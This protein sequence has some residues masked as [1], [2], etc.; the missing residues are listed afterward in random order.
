VWP[1]GPLVLIALVP[2]FAWQQHGG[3]YALWDA[4][5]AAGLL[6]IGLLI[7]MFVLRRLMGSWQQAGVAATIIPALLLV[8]KS[9]K[10]AIGALLAIV[11]LTVFVEW[12]QSGRVA[13]FK[14]A[15]LVI[16]VFSIAMLAR[17]G[18]IVN[19]MTEKHKVVLTQ[20]S[21]IGPVA[22][23]Q[24]PSIVHIVMDAYGSPATLK[25][26]FGHD[27][28]PFEAA[29]RKRGFVV[30]DHVVSPFN[31]TLFVIS[32]IMSGAEVR[33]AGEGVGAS[34]YRRDL[35]YTARNGAVPQALRAAGYT[36]ATA[37]S[38]YGFLDFDGIDVAPHLFTPTNL[39]AGL[40]SPASELPAAWVRNTMLKSA[41]APGTLAEVPQPYFYFQHLLAPHPPFTINS[42]GSRRQAMSTEIIDGSHFVMGSDERRAEYIAGYRSKAAFV[43]AAILKQFDALPPGPKVVIIHGDHGPGALLDTE[44]AAA[45]C[46]SERMTTFAAVYSNVP[47]VR[48][49]FASQTVQ[50]FYLVNIYRILFSALSSKPYDLLPA[51][52]QFLK[53][54]SL[55]QSTPLS[56][57]QISQPCKPPKRPDRP[58]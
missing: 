7:L 46:L 33:L 2:Y 21:P 47:E 42:D 36:F 27:S 56:L 35:G 38:G 48:A 53:W 50:P 9:Y 52:P 58:A 5:R 20:T 17:I 29:L 23:T 8:E 26:E 10:I 44:S 34:V 18:P 25:G 6:V 3:A 49:A 15:T 57:D 51:N 19:I 24:R 4:H 54:S 28:A 30:F 31:Q 11:V 32:S 1:V 39:E 55:N 45:S 12:K 41:L 13:A 22:F 40:L 14:K 37:R 16:N 43:E